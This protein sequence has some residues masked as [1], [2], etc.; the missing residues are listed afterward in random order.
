MFPG[1]FWL[2]F[3]LLGY[4]YAKKLIFPRFEE[5]A[6][7]KKNALGNNKM[8]TKYGSLELQL[9]WKENG[10]Q[11]TKGHQEGATDVAAELNCPLAPLLPKA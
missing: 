5:I 2:T 9:S 10:H 6:S 4:T 11:K 3:W 8:P 1:S 7:L